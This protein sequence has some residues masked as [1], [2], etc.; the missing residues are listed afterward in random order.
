MEQ[1]RRQHSIDTPQTLPP[2]TPEEAEA[3]KKRLTLQRALMREVVQL[4]FPTATGSE[5]SR[6][7]LTAW[8]GE[9][10]DDPNSLSARFA[11]L[12]EDPAN[13]KRTYDVSTPEK[14]RELLDELGYIPPKTDTVH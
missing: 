13:A 5:R 8:T 3:Y 7:A 6:L 1:M 2:P 11:R 12:M 14:V 4:E 10:A 9:D